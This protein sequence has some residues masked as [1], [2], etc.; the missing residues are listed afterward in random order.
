MTTGIEDRELA[1]REGDGLVVTLYWNPLDPA[2]TFVR[3][4]DR[5]SGG[6]FT[7]PTPEGVRPMDVFEHPFAYAGEVQ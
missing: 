7:V 6:E 2:E 5:K 1:V 3:V 4:V